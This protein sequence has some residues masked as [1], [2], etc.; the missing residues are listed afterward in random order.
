MELDTLNLLVTESIRRAEVLDDLGAPGAPSAHMDVSL[1][2]ERIAELVPASE[3]EGAIARRGAVRAA[4]AA[5]DAQ[6]ARELA[7]RFARADGT[8][9]DLA[10]DLACLA[11]AQACL[12]SPRGMVQSS[13]L[14]VL[15]ALVGASGHGD[16]ALV[17]A[18][19]RDFAGE[20]GA[21]IQLTA[22]SFVTLDDLHAT[23]PLEP[24][25]VIHFVG[26][27]RGEGRLLL[28]ESEPFS[29]ASLVALLVGRSPTLRCAVFTGCASADLAE[30]LVSHG[31][32]YAVVM[33][34]PLTD[35]LA[36]E[37]SRAFYRALAAGVAIEQAHLLGCH[38]LSLAFLPKGATPVLRSNMAHP[39]VV[40]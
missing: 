5:G 24:F 9:A 1:L 8:S 19:L 7:A 31:L 25:D 29:T 14:R 27:G 37:F 20:I 21:R 30:A 6:R 12:A 2:E 36:G 26:S 23:L 32:P 13:K 40:P 15:F 35:R 4:I 33:A 38:A 3:P 18:A 39:L 16:S 34:A 28:H 22:R 11:D 17:A 10:R